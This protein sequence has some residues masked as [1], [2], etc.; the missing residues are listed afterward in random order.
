MQTLRFSIN[1]QD[2][3]MGKTRVR[4]SRNNPM[5]EELGSHTL[6]FKILRNLHN[7]AILKSNNAAFVSPINKLDAILHIGPVQL[8]GELVKQSSNDLYYDCYFTTGNSTFRAKV[9]NVNMND[10][11]YTEVI[12]GSG[13]VSFTDALTASAY[14]SYPTYNYT[15]FPILAPNYYNESPWTYN[16]MINPWSYHPTNPSLVGFYP[17]TSRG[18]DL[19][20]APTF[21]LCFVIQKIFDLFGYSIANNDILDNT[22]LKTLVIPNFNTQGKV[23]T[24]F[25]QYDLTFAD[26]LPPVSINDFIEFLENEFNL[27]FF[28]SDISK[29]VHIK[30]NTPIIK[31]APTKR[32]ELISR[33]QELEDSIDG[34]TLS[35]AMDSEDSFSKITAI[36][37]YVLGLT[38]DNKTDLSSFPAGSYK[39]KLAKITNN[40]LYYLSKL[41]DASTDTWAWEE[42]TKDYFDY[43]EGQGDFEKHSEANPILTDNDYIYCYYG[44]GLYEFALFPKVGLSCINSVGLQEYKTFSSL[45]L[46]FY[47]GVVTGGGSFWNPSNVQ[48]VYPLASPDVYRAKGLT[49][50]K[51]YGRE[52]LSSANQSLKWDGSYGLYETHWKDFLYWYINLRKFATDLYELAFEE[53]FGIN[54]WEKYQAGDVSVLFRSMEIEFDFGSDAVN[55]GKCE[56]YIS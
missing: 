25:R 36:D 10:L 52:K 3:D 51:R 54:F 37:D 39:N 55:P 35:Y 42:L 49:S 32:L 33:E 53:I 21:Y 13:S 14:S 5:F 12:P 50:P 24:T 20:Y 4:Y 6:P 23:D 46:L 7:E 18:L 22:E 16:A 30:K 9:R 8:R 44:G 48:S 15:C 47:R 27:T 26:A 56:V 2:L 17:S 29:L 38:I 19:L 34:F 40:D 31:A 11:D 41:T 1:G 45:R 43:K 28:I